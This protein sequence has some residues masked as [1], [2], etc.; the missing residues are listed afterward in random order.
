MDENQ[1]K[2]L[3]VY[4]AVVIGLGWFGHVGMA[5]PEKTKRMRLAKDVA[6][7]KEKKE[8]YERAK[9]KLEEDAAGQ[10]AI[11]AELKA[12]LGRF[13]IP[14]GRQGERNAKYYDTFSISEQISAAAAGLTLNPRDPLDPERF[15]YQSKLVQEE[16]LAARAN[17]ITDPNDKPTLP[18]GKNKVWN[19]LG[20]DQVRF[21]YSAAGD[22]GAFLGFLDRLADQSYF[23]DLTMLD[24]W[25]KG[26]SGSTVNATLIVSV[27]DAS[28]GLVNPSGP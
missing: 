21:K 19:Y 20:V 18:E 1:K 13:V 4:M 26:A 28:D 12:L 10:K 14:K 22:F 2:A 8:A 3:A 27:L 25:Q 6:E 16:D 7:L 17:D 9:K 5:G 23:L 24:V 15:L 11:E